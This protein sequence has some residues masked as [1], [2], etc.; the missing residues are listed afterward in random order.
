MKATV[1]KNLL[2]DS[3]AYYDKNE[4]YEEFSKAEDGEGKVRNYLMRKAKN[5]VVLDAGC[6]T[7]KFL[8]ILEKNSKKYVGV[9]LSFEQLVKAKSKSRCEG[10][11]FINANLKEIMFSDNTFDLIIS[12]WVLGTITDLDERGKC[13]LELKRVLKPGGELILIENEVDN[14]FEVLRGRDKDFR[15]RDYN[16]WIIDNDFTR[17]ALIDTYFD[18]TNLSRARKCFL[19]IY[20]EDV[21]LKITCA[22][23][24]HKIGIFKFIK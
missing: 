4:Y 11:I 5:C 6:G 12:S 21:A 15:T 14:E 1:T 3:R 10:S 16:Q 20:G 13:L 2:K 22:K 23:I 9:D 8:E 17:D 7:G 19:E 24:E 18:F